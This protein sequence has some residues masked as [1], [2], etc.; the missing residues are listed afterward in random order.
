MPNKKGLYLLGLVAILLVGL[1]LAGFLSRLAQVKRNNHDANHNSLPQV[2]LLVAKPQD[3]PIQFVLPSVT[4]ANHVTPIWARADGYIKSLLVDIGDEVKQGQHLVELETPEIDQKYLQAVHDLE[5]AIA[6]R[7]AAKLFADRGEATLKLDS[8]AI[9]Q[10]DV[11]QRRANLLATEANVKAAVANKNYYKDLMEFK[12]VVAPFDGVITERNVDVGSLITAGSSGNPQQLFVM[13]TSDIIR[14]FVNVPQTFFRSIHEGLEGSTNIREFG[15]KT[16]TS[17]VRRYAKSLDQPSHTM[18]TEL[19]IDNKN[20]EL[21]P[22]LYAEVTFS[23]KPDLPYFIVPTPALI[24]RESTP[25]I[26]VVD[27]QDVVH[28]KPVKVGLDYGK[29][30]EI[31]EGIEPGDNIVIN[32]T[33]KIRNGVKVAHHKA[34]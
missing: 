2:T 22:G 13:S 20:G 16:F 7:D 9:S 26:A 10:E 15:S 32:P 29:S 18:L 24:I 19:H 6:R 1:F 23:F 33:E 27:A 12:Y 8:Q 28:I 30:V 17:V 11:E 3:E 14:I 34:A 4:E 5:T 25:K 21:V 31:I